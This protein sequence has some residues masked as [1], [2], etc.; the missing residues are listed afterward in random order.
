MRASK[1][2]SPLKMYPLSHLQTVT[3]NSFKLI[4]VQKWVKSCLVAAF[5]AFKAT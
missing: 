1:H 4:H 2:P 5:I 3:C